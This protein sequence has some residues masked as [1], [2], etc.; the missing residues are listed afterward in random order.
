MEPAAASFG[1]NVTGANQRIL[2]TSDRDGNSELYSMNADG[3]D[4]IR[5]TN[6]PAADF[7]GVWSPDGK[8]IAFQSSRDNPA[9][10][11]YTMNVDGTGIIRLTQ[12]IG[13]SQMPTWSKDGKQIAFVSTRDGVNPPALNPND[14]EIYVINADGTNIQRL[15]HNSYMETAPAWSPDGKQIAFVSNQDSES[16]GDLYVMN[17][18]G[19]GVKR[20]TQFDWVSYP[21]WDPHS[22]LIAL[23]VYD[24]AAPGIYLIDPATL[25][26]TRL[27]FS[28]FATDLLPSFSP[29]GTKI[30]FTSTRDG[31]Y[32]IYS[33]NVDGSQPTRL[34]NAPSFDWFARWSR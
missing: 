31:N 1:K 32:E 19:G 13:G 21:S 12:S 11:I 14:F 29:D 8:R 3:T 26:H 15:T 20:L 18:D 4:Q 7:Y 2:F 23:S 5:L 27:T 30:S 28:G 16:K 6:H 22:R 17:T 10:E 24:A 33:M 25:A 34:T 9:G